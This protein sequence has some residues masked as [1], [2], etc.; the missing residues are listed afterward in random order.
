MEFIVEIAPAEPITKPTP[1]IKPITRPGQDDPWN[2]PQPLIDSPPK[3]I[4]LI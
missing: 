4:S 3:A 1:V 2:I